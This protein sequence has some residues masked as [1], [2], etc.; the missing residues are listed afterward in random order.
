MKLLKIGTLNIPK[1]RWL[2]ALEIFD[3][4]YVFCYADEEQIK[5]ENIRYIKFAS[6]SN[7][8]NFFNRVLI[9][10]VNYSNT[11][12]RF[13]FNFWIFVMRL[14]NFTILKKIE[15]LEIDFVH[16]SYNDFDESGL[17]TILC[18]NII[19][20][21]LTRSYKEYRHQKNFIEKLNFEMANRIIFNQIENQRYFFDKYKNV[22]WDNKEIIVGLDEDYRSENIVEFVSDYEKLSSLD[23][24]IH[25][26]I[27]SAWVLSD[28]L[29]K[30]SGPRLFY[31]P[32]I[33][34]FI[35]NGFIIHLHAKK[36]YRDSKG[37]NQYNRLQDK[38]PKKFFIEKPLDFENFSN[39]SY[40]ILSRYDFGILHNIA[41]DSP[42]S[43]FDQYNIPH[44]FYEYQIS[45]VI[46]IIKKGET[47]VLE[48]LFETYGVGLVYES[49]S[50]LKEVN[51]QEYV[52]FKKTFKE[53][54]K[55]LYP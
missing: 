10:M 43:E 14:L 16:S 51:R 44:R 41:V 12:N 28:D 21:P 49:L 4:I 55:C 40:K 25:V 11:R 50:E 38:Y 26:V 46:P 8:K 3:V 48:R 17:L 20:K 36:I 30:R 23:G 54:I 34:N 18:K 1:N 15:S 7:L 9:F 19:K 32:L 31:I 22:Y 24:L 35:K 53:Y 13:F 47:V 5:H 29:D 52:F 37:V 45:E 2:D 39:E 33:E 6:N 42:I 27:L